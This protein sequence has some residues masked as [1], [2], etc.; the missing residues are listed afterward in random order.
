MSLQAVIAGAGETAYRRH[1]DAH[2]TTP[3]LLAEAARLALGDARMEPADIDGLGVASFSLAPDRAIDLA[4]RLGLQVSWLMDDGTGGASAVDMLQHARR[5]VEAGDAQ[6]ILLVAGDRMESGDFAGLVDGYNTATRDH[7]APLPAGGPNP[8]FALLTRRHMLRHRLG[9]EVYGRLVV[10][11]RAWAATSPNAAYRA[12]L[13]LRDYLRAPMVADPLGLFDCVPVVSG[14]AAVVV[15]SKGVSGAGVRVCALVAAH[16]TDGQEGDG[17][18]TGLAAV[19]DR[20]WQEAGCG[21]SD[22]DVVSA[23]DDYPAMVLVQLDDLGFA[24][25]RGWKL[26]SI[27]LLRGSCR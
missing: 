11:Q 5:A 21:P 25:R 16:N 1:A 9:R 2:L 3:R 26:L 13:E 27:G 23:Y 19:R 10:A 4:F 12:P 24:G 8:L 17:L 15:T 6:A 20:L 14:A 18:A 7:L 22:I